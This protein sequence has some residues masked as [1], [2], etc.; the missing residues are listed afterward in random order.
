M[1]D[2][3]DRAHEDANVRREMP[4]AK[5][6]SIN[7]GIGE[8][9]HMDKIKQNEQDQARKSRQ[10]SDIFDKPDVNRLLDKQ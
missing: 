1:T 6:E 2:P 3:G 4:D 9:G 5:P 10:G 8:E 7:P